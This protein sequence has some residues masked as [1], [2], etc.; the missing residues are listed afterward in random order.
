M[1]ETVPFAASF[2]EV[3]QLPASRFYGRVDWGDGTTSDG[4]VTKTGDTT[5]AVSGAHAYASPGQYRVTTIFGYVPLHPGN[6][7]ALHQL[8]HSGDRRIT[9]RG[10]AGQLWGIFV[11]ARSCFWPLAEE[12]LAGFEGLV[13]A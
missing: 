11:V 2:M 6:D 10:K 9:R 8:Q 7:F 3:G 5:Y 12:G 4:E 1:G 13:R